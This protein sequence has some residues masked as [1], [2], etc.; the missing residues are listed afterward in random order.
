M[1][2]L[3]GCGTC[4]KKW[5]GV[6]AAHCGACHTTFTSLATFDIHLPSNK[7]CGSP[8]ARKL[9][10][11]EKSW[12]TV[13]GTPVD[14]DKEAWWSNPKNDKSDGLTESDEA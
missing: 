4:G 6:R 14:P 2:E 5:S 11:F 10:P 7:G 1:A 8:S 12:G 3:T 9:V 13:W